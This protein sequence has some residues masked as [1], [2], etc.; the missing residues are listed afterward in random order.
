MRAASTPSQLRDEARQ[1]FEALCQF[2]EQVWMASVI[3]C[4][5]IDRRHEAFLPNR[6]E[7]NMPVPFIVPHAHL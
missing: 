7:M 2:Q 5:V 6:D 3:L 4:V 1:P